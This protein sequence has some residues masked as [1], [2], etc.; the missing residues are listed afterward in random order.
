MEYGTNGQPGCE[1]GGSYGVRIET[2]AIPNQPGAMANDT[3]TGNNITVTA[4]ACNAMGFDLIYIPAT[5]SGLNVT[6]NTITTINGGQ[7][8][9]QDAGFQFDDAS[10]NGISITGNTVTSSNEWMYGYW[11]GYNGIVVGHNTWEGSPQ[12]TFKAQDG[13]CDPT[14][15]DSQVT[16][17]VSINITDN[18]PNK[19]SCGAESTAT[20][21]INGQVTQCKPNQ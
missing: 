5:A 4:N 20:V 19:V 6:G 11:D 3:V 16:C 12:F 13:G 15:S 1:N 2:L 7:S 17:P 10:G 18:L 8:G 9:A 21:T 14:Q